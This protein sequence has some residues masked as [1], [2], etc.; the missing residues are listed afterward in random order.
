MRK[1]LKLEILSPLIKLQGLD[2]TENHMIEKEQLILLQQV[3]N[4]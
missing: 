3:P 1:H 2:I 4:L